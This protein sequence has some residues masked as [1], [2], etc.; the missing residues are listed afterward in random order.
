ML[1]QTPNKQMSV[2]CPSPP[3]LVQNI[4]ILENIV[5]PSSHILIEDGSI[6]KELSAQSNENLGDGIEIAMKYADNILI[7]QL[8]NSVPK[9]PEN[10]SSDAAINVSGPSTIDK[11][12]L[13]KRK[14]KVLSPQEKLSKITVEPH[15]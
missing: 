8:N 9:V 1:N 12:N 7:P 10:K 11:R 5:S 15:I 3:L 14:A 4:P 2:G 13:K 6:A